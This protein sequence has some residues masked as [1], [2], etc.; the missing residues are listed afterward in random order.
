[1]T[2]PIRITDER[3]IDAAKNFAQTRKHM[4][5]DFA[6]LQLKHAKESQDLFAQYRKTFRDYFRIA[7]EAHL[8]DPDEAFSKETHALDISY[9]DYDIVF[10]ITKPQE[11]QNLDP[12][13]ETSG[14]PDPETPARIVVN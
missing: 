13:D 9:V 7:T 11:N 2:K 3:G 10:L 12:G 14:D 1:M 4:Q 5:K 8:T 6:L